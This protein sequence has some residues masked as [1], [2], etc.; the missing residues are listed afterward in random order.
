ME[1][2]NCEL[3]AFDL[4]GTTVNDDGVVLRAFEKAFNESQPEYWKERRKQWLQYVTETMGR[5]KIEVFT[6]ILG[7]VEMARVATTVFEEA[8]IAEVEKG[9]VDAIPGTL[10]LFYDLHDSG[11]AVGVTTGFSRRVL[12]AIIGSLDWS[13]LIDCSS[14][15]EEAGGGRPSPAMLEHLSRQVSLSSPNRS[16]VIGDTQ[17]DIEAGIAFGAMQVIGV[18]SG[19]HSEAKLIAAGATRIINSVA[20][21]N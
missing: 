5:S 2:K 16:I 15:P 19:A 11:I 7:D 12:D 9:Q 14:T 4:A 10:Q 13:A 6:D 21:L 20:D 1:I 17:A 3:I 8:Y 18:R